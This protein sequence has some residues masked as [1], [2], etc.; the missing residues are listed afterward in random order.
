MENFIFFGS[1][2]GIVVLATAL[3]V[4]KLRRNARERAEQSRKAISRNLSYGSSSTRIS[5]SGVR[6]RTAESSPTRRQESTGT[7]VDNGAATYAALGYYGGGS[8]S[9]SC[10]TSSSSSD[11]SSSCSS[12][13]GGGGGGGD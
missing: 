11:S 2:A 1:I 6:T 9:D 7:Y 10:S 5:S 4:R 12:D 8:T 13:G 3:I